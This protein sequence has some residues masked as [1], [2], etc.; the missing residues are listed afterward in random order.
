MKK[1]LEK[2]TLYNKKSTEDK[3]MLTRTE[4]SKPLTLKF[5]DTKG[6]GAVKFKNTYLLQHKQKLLLLT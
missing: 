5:T 4:S 3:N 1:R 2:K 6:W